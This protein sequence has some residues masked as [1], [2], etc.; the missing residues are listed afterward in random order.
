MAGPVHKVNVELFVD[1][2]K[3]RDDAFSIVRD[4][5]ECAMLEDGQQTRRLSRD[6]HVA[7]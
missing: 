5:V 6:G 7:L 1:G 3:D 4:V 2:V